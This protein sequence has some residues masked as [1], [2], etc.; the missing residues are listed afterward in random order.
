MADRPVYIDSNI[1]LYSLMEDS[2]IPLDERI[3]KQQIAN[4]LITTC[5]VIS[6]STQVINEV[7]FNL[8][9]KAGKTE[10]EIQDVIQD[11]YDLC[12]IVSLDDSVLL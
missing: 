10:S 12:E 1:W 2:R 8:I 7:C 5:E 3:R 6:V 4:D 9:R 11:F